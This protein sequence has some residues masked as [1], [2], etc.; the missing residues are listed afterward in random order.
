M[1]VPPRPEVAALKPAVHGGPDHAELERLGRRPDEVLDFSVNANP[2]GPSSKVY[3][4][5][6][7]VDVARYPDPECL[8]LRRTLAAVHGVAPEN[9]IAG[10]G[11]AELMWLLGLAYLN[12]GD[13]V[14]IIGPT[15]GEYE[16]VVR[17]MGAEPVHYR[18]VP[19]DL[20]PDVDEIVRLMVRHGPKLTFLC[21][22]NNPTGQ[23][24]SAEDVERI[25]AAATHGF[26]VLDEAYVFFVEDAW[27]ATPLVFRGNLVIL[28]SMTK[29]Y[30]L[31]GLRLG[32]ALA[33]EEAT[34]VLRRVRPPWNVNAAAQAAGNAALEDVEHLARAKEAVLE[35]KHYLME[36]LPKLGLMPV[37]SRANLFLV[38]VGDAS[39]IYAKLLEK[40]VKVRNCTSFGLP[41]YIR[42]GA[43]TLPECQRLVAVLREVLGK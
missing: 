37:P 2:V 8:L 24:L 1:S 16:T 27:P 3:E 14:L 42:L 36:A 4:A 39:A 43:R 18:A 30:A 7:V 31:A 5:L 22:P 23:Y 17:L 6:S 26:L 13:S 34:S 38:E 19:P 41:N 15:F 12:S 11:S 33:A 10:N 20:R 28:R 21:N 35:G 32:Y 9:I 29:D 25:L 40:G